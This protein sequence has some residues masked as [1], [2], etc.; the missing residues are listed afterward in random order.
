[1]Y[2]IKYE[3]IDTIFNIS[4]KH[5]AQYF[6][7]QIFYLG[8]YEVSKMCQLEVKC[9]S[10]TGIGYAETVGSNGCRRCFRI[11]EFKLFTSSCTVI[12]SQ[13]IAAGS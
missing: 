2:I 13:S 4:S 5:F 12:C 1:M 8:P 6:V 7:I 3:M 10:P 9:G 11:A